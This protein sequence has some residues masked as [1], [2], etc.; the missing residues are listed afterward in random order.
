[1]ILFV[2]TLMIYEIQGGMSM[3]EFLI[4]YLLTYLFDFILFSNIPSLET[5][6]E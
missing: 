3:K 5:R 4:E 1:M 6:V 2:E